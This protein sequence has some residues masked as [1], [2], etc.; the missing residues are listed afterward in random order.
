MK[1]DSLEKLLFEGVSD[2]F[3]SSA[4]LAFKVANAVHDKGGRAVIVG[5][6]V[7]DLLLK[8]KKQNVQLKDIDIEVFGIEKEDLRN[9]LCV[10]GRVLEVGASFAVFKLKGLDISLPRR[11]SKVAAGHKG[12][13]IETDPSLS[14]REASRRRSF[15]INSMG[16][17]PITGEL[18]DSWEGYQDLKNH[19]L[20]AV[21]PETFVED[22]L[23][24]LRGMQ[25]AGRFNLSIDETTL[26]L[27]KSVPLDDLSYERIGEEWMKLLLLSERPSIGLQ[28]GMDMGIL[29]KL[30]P[31]LFGLAGVS[32]QSDWHPEGDVWEHTKLTVD[33][34]AAIVRREKLDKEQ[35][36]ILMLAALLHDV[37]KPPTTELSEGFIHSYNHH[38]VGQEIAENF[39]LKIK[40]SKRVI[41][42]VLPL[43][44][45]HLF[46]TFAPE[47]GE[48]AL[49]RLAVRLKPATIRLLAYV[50]EADLIG[51]KA[52]IE[53]IERCRKLLD[54]ALKLELAESMPEPFLTG[55]LLIVR[56]FQPGPVF[57]EILDDAYEAQ[58]NGEFNST[59]GA[60]EW[61]K[62]RGKE[63]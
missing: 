19:V 56:G 17:D 20:R 14:F 23:R 33:A 55:K 28:A 59:D 43:I 31:E 45:E 30:H 18:L 22:S 62:N 3:A 6:T 11:D 41:Q 50:I 38:I 21:D 48:K 25:L 7:R 2:E 1:L 51:M 27:C 16:L 53:R 5:G 58:L 46:L 42:S 13:R 34:M 10:F 9:I 26:D 35:M 4:R 29:F 49:R 54:D 32:Q 40:R 8:T 24:V 63:E 12:F 44:Q 39:L 37:G 60:L 57:G 15:T 61:L 36:E 52:G 47:P